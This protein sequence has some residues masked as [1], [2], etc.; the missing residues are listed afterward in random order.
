V[1]STPYLNDF[2]AFLHHFVIH[3]DP[4]DQAKRWTKQSQQGQEATAR[5][6]G[7]YI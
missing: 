4:D 1:L 3:K 5:I 7:A 2:W 6:S